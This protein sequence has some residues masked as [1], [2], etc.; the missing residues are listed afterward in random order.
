GDATRDAI[1][2]AVIVERVIERRLNVTFAHE[3]TGV[4]YRVLDEFGLHLEPG[5]YDSEAHGTVWAP[6]SRVDQL[7][8]RLGELAHEGVTIAPGELRV[9]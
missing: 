4:V 8:K 6:E 1:A 9:R 2:A 7:T 5:E 3:R